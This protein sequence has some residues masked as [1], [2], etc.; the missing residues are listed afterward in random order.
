MGL[1]SRVSSRT[2]R[3]NMPFDLQ[4]AELDPSKSK[5]GYFPKVKVTDEIRRLVENIIFTNNVV[6]I[7]ESDDT[8]R[9]FFN[10]ANIAL[11][12]QN[13][14]Q[15]TRSDKRV[16]AL[17]LDELPLSEKQQVQKH[18]YD[19]RTQGTN[20]PYIAVCGKSY[21]TLKSFVKFIQEDKGKKFC[22]FM[23]KCPDNYLELPKE[24]KDQFDK[25]K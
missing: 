14:P 18:L 2:Y 7:G 6:L 15:L 12:L 19:T 23:E 20:Q 3:A 10:I 22:Q 4:K 9:E 11:K 25:S 21:T 1:I 17:D 8:Y 16:A 5:I 13:K 24:L